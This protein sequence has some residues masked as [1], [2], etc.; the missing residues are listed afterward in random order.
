MPKINP[1]SFD[2]VNRVLAYDAET[3]VFTWKVDVAR[4]VKAGDKAGCAKGARLSKKTGKMHR[5]VY[6]RIGNIDSP[7]ARI[8][9][10]LHHGEFPKGNL[11]FVDGDT[12][13]LRIS[14]LRETIWFKPSEE[15]ETLKN[16]KMNKTTMRHYALKRYYGI[17]GEQYG[18]ML[19][20]QKG[21]CA[22]CG[23]PETA[24]FRGVPKVMHVDH[25]HETGKVR[26]LLCGMCNGMLGL[27]KDDTAKLRAAA[28]YLEKHSGKTATVTPL[29]VVKEPE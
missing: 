16:R 10:L 1:L 12:E 20:A 4:N 29:H 9:W 19:A 17:T 7:A 22:I 15:G 13:N 5:Y 11:Q 28:A 18:E 27:A 6:I 25:C 21:V 2:E 3:G 26:A 8:A 23:Q 14:N 24:M